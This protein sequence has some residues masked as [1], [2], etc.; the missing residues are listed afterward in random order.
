LAD[1]QEQFQSNRRR[2][3][4]ESLYLHEASL[5]AVS[6]LVQGMVSV[7]G[8]APRVLAGINVHT[9]NLRCSEIIRTGEVHVSS[10]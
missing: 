8:L 2:A 1:L 9:L 5:D 3:V 7:T 4:L 6:H 10:E